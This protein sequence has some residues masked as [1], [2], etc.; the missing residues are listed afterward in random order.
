MTDLTSFTVRPFR[1]LASLWAH[2]ALRYTRRE[3]AA[4]A[5]LVE[6]SAAARSLKDSQVL[7]HGRDSCCLGDCANEGGD[8]NTKCCRF[9]SNLKVTCTSADP[10]CCA[11]VDFT[12]GNSVNGAI[13]S[14]QPD[15]CNL[16]SARSHQDTVV[17]FCRCRLVQQCWSD[18]VCAS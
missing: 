9:L 11:P 3:S 2:P 15:S 5:T 10:T 14:T 6:S 18:P 8:N 12:V 4:Q 16:T 17:W 7:K 13:D 1:T